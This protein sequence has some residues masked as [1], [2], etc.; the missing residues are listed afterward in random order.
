[1]KKFWDWVKNQNLLAWVVFILSSSVLLISY[2]YQAEA[3]PKTSLCMFYNLT[4]LPCP[5]CGLTRSFCSIAKGQLFLSF[6]FHSL[7][8]LMFIGTLF[9]WIFSFL[10][11][12]YVK[13]PFEVIKSLSTNDLFIK[14]SLCIFF[15]HWTIRLGIIFL[16]SAYK[17]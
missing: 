5:G 1:M 3:N 4:S 14:A 17:D 7:G 15:I 13:K 12:F 10:T 2:F 6:Y 16:H 8:P 11:F 9:A